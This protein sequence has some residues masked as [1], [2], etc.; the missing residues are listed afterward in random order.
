MQQATVD[1]DGTDW[2]LGEVHVSL[3]RRVESRLIEI[4]KPVAATTID[5]TLCSS[6]HSTVEPRK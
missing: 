6:L 1:G 5:Q 3:M 2:G 4:P